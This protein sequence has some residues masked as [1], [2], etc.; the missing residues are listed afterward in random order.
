[1]SYQNNHTALLLFSRSSREESAAKNFLPHQHAG[2]NIKLVQKMIDR[3]IQ[4]ASRSGLPFFVWDEALQSGTTFGEKLANAIEAIFQ[5]GFPKVIVIGNDCLSLKSSHI[6]QAA[7]ALHTHESVVAPTKR[8]GAYLIGLTQNSFDKKR[9]EEVRWQSSLACQDLL[10]LCPAPSVFQLPLL[11][12]V[13]DFMDL[14]KQ[15]SVLSKDDPFRSYAERMMASRPTY[16]SLLQ[17]ATT[18]NYPY[19]FGLT[20]PPF[21]SPSF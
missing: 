17:Y 18:F 11:N 14:Q 21:I 9:F 5:K 13:N 8:G 15:V 1:M 20:A 12:D 4:V 3:S 6:R 10:Q 19:F 2:Q 16:F 7:L